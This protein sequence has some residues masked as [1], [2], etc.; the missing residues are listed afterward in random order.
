MKSFKKYLNEIDSYVPSYSD[1]KGNEFPVYDWPD[2]DVP[3]RDIQPRRP[4][5]GDLP[6]WFQGNEEDF[7]KFVEEIMDWLKKQMGLLKWALLHNPFSGFPRMPVCDAGASAA[8]AQQ[9][10]DYFNAVM[11]YLI[12]HFQEQY[13]DWFE[14]NPDGTFLDWLQE[15]DWWPF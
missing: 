10:V 5:W 8:C 7:Q 11:E 13:Q 3:K 15:Q 6:W 14:S 1:N 4:S 12:N 9:W 2:K